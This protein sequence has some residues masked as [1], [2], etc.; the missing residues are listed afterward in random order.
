MQRRTSQ[1][2]PRLLAYS[3]IGKPP[4]NVPWFSEIELTAIIRATMAFH[5]EHQAEGVFQ[6]N[7]LQEPDGQ[8]LTKRG[9][10]P[11]LIQQG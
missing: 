8:V 2:L 5:N 4:I 11:D 6:G 3:S 7:G 10:I 1:Q 9:E